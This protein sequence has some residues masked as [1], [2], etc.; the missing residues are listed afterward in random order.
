MQI[1]SHSS[2]RI[3]FVGKNM[4]ISLKCNQTVYYHNFGFLFGGDDDNSPDG[5]K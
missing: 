4:K 2:F 5:V 3:V 1:L